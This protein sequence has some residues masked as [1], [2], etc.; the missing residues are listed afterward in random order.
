ADDAVGKRVHV[1]EKRP[2]EPLRNAASGRDDL[3]LK[4]V[5]K[6]AGAT[7]V[8]TRGRRGDL[9][10]LRRP[11]VCQRPRQLALR[12]PPLRS[13]AA[14]GDDQRKEQNRRNGPQHSPLMPESARTE[15]RDV[16]R[17]SLKSC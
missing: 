2:S 7:A 1:L 13:A 5:G 6:P 12:G 9:G 11:S 8:A 4:G 17:E 3:R 14:A 16:D 15:P 10:S